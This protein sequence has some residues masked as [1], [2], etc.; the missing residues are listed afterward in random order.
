M[1]T[2]EHEA[3]RRSSAA[4]RGVDP[5]LRPFGAS[6]AYGWVP[7]FEHMGA[8]TS[9]GGWASPSALERFAERGI[10]YW[11]T[12]NRP[13]YPSYP[14]SVPRIIGPDLYYRHVSH[15][16]AWAS[17]RLSYGWLNAHRYDYVPASHPHARRIRCGRSGLPADSARG[18]TAYLR[19]VRRRWRNGAAMTPAKRDI[20]TEAARRNRSQSC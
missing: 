14:L 4:L 16:F 12:C 2:E 17:W 10:D 9:T 1:R 11:G 15:Y 6:Y 3:R 5:A 7:Y 13:C 19:V 8:L 18:R 20:S